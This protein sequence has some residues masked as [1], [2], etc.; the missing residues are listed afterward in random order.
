M[1]HI[2]L[3][4]EN[5]IF[6]NKIIVEDQLSNIFYEVLTPAK[7]E[8][9]MI[10]KQDH[11]TLIELRDAYLSLAK[12]IGNISTLEDA[13]KKRLIKN[14]YQNLIRCLINYYTC[15]KIKNSIEKYDKTTF[16][17]IERRTNK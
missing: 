11:C 6:D 9:A 7:N 2:E 17:K 8:V 13:E 4:I 15:L 12:S 3:Q 16:G 5:M 1:Y 14:T 10:S